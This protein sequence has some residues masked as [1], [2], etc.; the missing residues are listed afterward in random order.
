MKIG[1]KLYIGS[2]YHISRG[3]DDVQGGLATID[4]IEFSKFLPSDHYNYTMVGF[5]EIPGTG[6]NL[7]YLLE[8]Q[9]KWAIEFAGC[10]ARPDPDID[11]P[12]IESGDI[13]NCEVYH[14][15]DIW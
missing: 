1:D 15:E 7:N 3:S 13:V 4:S 11:R 2:S 10:E 6:Y 5:E 9:E 14:G 8:N 12:W